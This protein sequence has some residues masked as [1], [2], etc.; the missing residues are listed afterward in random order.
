MPRWIGSGAPLGRVGR[1]RLVGRDLGFRV[2]RGLGFRQFPKPHPRGA[3]VFATL[4]ATLYALCTTLCTLPKE[5]YDFLQLVLSEITW[6][7]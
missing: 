2:W 4:A 5:I 6:R 3:W 1:S 7:K